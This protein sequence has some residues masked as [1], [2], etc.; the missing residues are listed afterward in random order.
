[1]KPTA[2][3]DHR[4]IAAP[5]RALVEAFDAFAAEAQSIADEAARSPDERLKDL[6]AMTAA[7]GE[8]A[9]R[10]LQGIRKEVVTDRFRSWS[11]LIAWCGYAAAPA[12]QY[13]LDL[14]GEPD[15]AR[16]PIEALFTAVRLLRCVAGCKDDYNLRDRVYIPGDWMRQAG[17]DVESLGADTATAALK[18]ALGRMLD[19][20]DRLLVVARAAP[21][22]I[23]DRRLRRAVAV[24]FV[25][26]R[27][28]CARLRRSDPLSARVAP[29]TLDRWLALVYGLAWCACARHTP[30][31]T[32]EAG[33][34]R[35]ST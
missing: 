32:N 8:Y 33:Q 35:R 19:G 12:G 6:D 11:E 1:M 7:E 25:G 3:L 23:R 22:V 13:V 29:A 17:A 5:H 4:L 27:R 9:S 14:H 26:A 15:S 24:S 20:V 10:V 30:N 28:W 34:W 31:T 21:G 2:T 16:R 18:N